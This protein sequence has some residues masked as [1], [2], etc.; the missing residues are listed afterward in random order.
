MKILLCVLLTLNLSACSKVTTVDGPEGPTSLRTA[1]PWAT[2]PGGR[3]YIVSDAWRVCFVVVRNGI[4]DGS[5]D[6]V[7]R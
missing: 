6:C 5:I 1:E 3:I 2:V 4:V 7:S